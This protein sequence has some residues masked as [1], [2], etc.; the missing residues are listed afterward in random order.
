MFIKISEL[1]KS[2]ESAEAFALV[3]V[4]VFLL[5]FDFVFLAEY[6]ESISDFIS[7]LIFECQQS[8]NPENEFDDVDCHKDLQQFFIDHIV[9]FCGISCFEKSCDGDDLI[10]KHE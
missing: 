7:F 2:F 1:S 8:K 10:D 6:K 3:L 5:F 9:V 4:I